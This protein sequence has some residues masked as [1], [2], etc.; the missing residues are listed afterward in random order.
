MSTSTTGLHCT[1]NGVIILQIGESLEL[2]EGN[3]VRAVITCLYQNNQLI[4]LNQSIVHTCPN[5]P[6]PGHNC[7]FVGFD[8]TG[9]CK[10]YN[11]EQGKSQCLPANYT[12][13]LRLE[14]CELNVTMT[15]CEGQCESSAEYNAMTGRIMHKCGCCVQKTYEKKTALLQCETGLPKPQEYMVL[16]KCECNYEYCR[17]TSKYII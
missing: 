4:L 8:S 6:P 1:V 5:E 15:R 11:C 16:K 2:K 17:D 13:T 14:G 7:R 3:C 9:C 10:L 12:E